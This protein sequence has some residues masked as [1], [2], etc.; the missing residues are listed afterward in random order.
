MST[1]AAIAIMQNHIYM[2]PKDGDH[3]SP[4]PAL[5]ALANHGYMYVSSVATCCLPTDELVPA[6]DTAITSAG[7]S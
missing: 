2:T 4:C 1:F 5:N 3:R 7:G 6:H